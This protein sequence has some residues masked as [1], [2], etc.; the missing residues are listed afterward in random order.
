[1]K[2][3]L[4]TNII[5]HR[6]SSRVLNENI[7]QL[8]YWLD[9]LRYTKCIHSLT[10][11]EIEKYKDE[12]VKKSLLA[13]MQSYELL[14]L[15]SPLHHDVEIAS[16]EIDVNDGNTFIQIQPLNQELIIN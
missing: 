4:D 3:L 12:L 1:M 8:F 11:K 16:K 10:V 13:K 15:S 5:L 2:A 7:G 14:E 6:E 9:K